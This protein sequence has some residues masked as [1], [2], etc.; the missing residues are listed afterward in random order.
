M[1]FVFLSVSPLTMKI[2]PGGFHPIRWTLWNLS[3]YLTT[4]DLHQRSNNRRVF[5]QH[6]I[7]GCMCRSGNVD[8]FQ[9]NW[10]LFFS[11]HVQFDSGFHVMTVNKVVWNG[12]TIILGLHHTTMSLEV[13]WKRPVWF[14]LKI[15][16]FFFSVWEIPDWGGCSQNLISSRELR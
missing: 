10:E 13:G 15:S 2:H 3:M 12:P 5:L 11:R 7:Q 9:W 1:S 16:L 4:L 6:Y 8:V 14:S